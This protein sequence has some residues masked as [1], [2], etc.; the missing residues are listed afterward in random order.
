MA[1]RRNRFN[2]ANDTSP[3]QG[4]VPGMRREFDRNRDPFKRAELDDLKKTESQRRSESERWEDQVKDYRR[5]ST[6]VAKDKPRHDLRPPRD[7]SKESDRLKFAHEWMRE[8][9]EAAMAQ[10]AP[11]QERAHAR[12]RAQSQPTMTHEQTHTPTRSGPSR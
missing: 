3:L 1:G 4:K 6:M 2:A 7:L 12:L 11:D 8:Q 10:A 5:G 9:R